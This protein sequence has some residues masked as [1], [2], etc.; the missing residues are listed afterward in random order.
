MA[1]PIFGHLAQ[2]VSELMGILVTDAKVALN[3]KP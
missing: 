2:L 1:C 3:P